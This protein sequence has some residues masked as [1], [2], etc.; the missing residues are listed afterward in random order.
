MRLEGQGLDAA[1]DADPT[2][3]P[4]RASETDR[5]HRESPDQVGPAG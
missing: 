1:H 3:W 2:A 4:S 5:T